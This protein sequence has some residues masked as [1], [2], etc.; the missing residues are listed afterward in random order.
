MDNF[1]NASHLIFDAIAQNDMNDLKIALQSV[2]DALETAD[3][4]L[5]TPLLYACYC[6]HSRIVDYLLG[7]GADHGRLNLFGKHKTKTD[8]PQTKQLSHFKEREKETICN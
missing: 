4:S 8:F 2:P 5:N 3:R 6:G 1:E 7:L